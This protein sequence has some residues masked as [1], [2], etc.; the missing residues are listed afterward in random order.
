MKIAIT[1]NI[2]VGKSTLC[3]SLARVFKHAEVRQEVVKDS[4]YFKVFST[5][6]ESFK[7]ESFKP[8]SNR[9]SAGDLYQVKYAIHN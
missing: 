3:D 7:P 9:V 4:R 8:E 1:G 6:L 5:E 2:G